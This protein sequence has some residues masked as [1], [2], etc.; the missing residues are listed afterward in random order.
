MNRFWDKVE[1]TDTCWN[2]IAASRGN[3]YGCFKYERKTVDTHRMSWFFTYGIWPKK[4][5]LH[6]CNNRI[7]VRPDHLYEGTPKENYWDMR[8]NGNAHIPQSIY[9]TD[10]QKK[11]HQ[12]EVRRKNLERWHKRGKYLRDIRKGKIKNIPR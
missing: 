1:K 6:K 4:W 2:W 7:C 12:E 8:N 10:E 9:Q 5:I 3:G 11:L